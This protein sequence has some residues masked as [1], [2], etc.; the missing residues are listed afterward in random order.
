MLQRARRFQ[1]C[2]CVRWWG[3]SKKWHGKVQQRTINTNLLPAWW[4]TSSQVGVVSIAVNAIYLMYW[5]ITTSPLCAPAEGSPAVSQQGHQR[6]IDWGVVLFLQADPHSCSCLL[7][8]LHPTLPLPAHYSPSI[9]L[10]FCLPVPFLSPFLP[11]S[12]PFPYLCLS[13]LRGLP[14]GHTAGPLSQKKKKKKSMV[15]F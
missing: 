7:R 14:T 3:V 12:V 2:V 9:Y 11:V 10:F 4:A 1:V 5:P 13:A 15:S 8:F 6:T